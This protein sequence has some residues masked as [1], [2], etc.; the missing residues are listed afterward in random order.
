ML[1]V[2]LTAAALTFG[3]PAQVK[4]EKWEVA[5]APL[6]GQ[7]IEQGKKRKDWLKR[8]RKVNQQANAMPY[9]P[10]AYGD[11]WELPSEFWRH[12]GDCEDYAIAKYY[13]LR[14][15]G[16]PERDMRVAVARLPWGEIHAVLLVWLNGQM[17][18]LDNMNP[19]V[20]PGEY[21]KNLHLFYTVSR[22][23]FW[24]HDLPPGVTA[25]AAE[26]KP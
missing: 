17:M 15:Q 24:L 1:S 16:F 2:L 5:V 20:M 14:K 8:I 4:I 7:P 25:T 6:A 10:D 12:G 22:A 9:V 11:V 26:K 23:G 21:I 19:D 13:R 18:V 3:T